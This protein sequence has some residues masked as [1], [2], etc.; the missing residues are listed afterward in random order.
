MSLDATRIQMDASVSNTCIGCAR[1]QSD[2]TRIR[3]ESR[4][5]SYARSSTAVTGCARIQ[6]DATRIGENE[7]SRFLLTAV[8][9]GCVRI[10]MDAARIRICRSQ[11]I[12]RDSLVVF[13]IS[14][15]I[16]TF[17]PIQFCLVQMQ[18][19]TFSTTFGECSK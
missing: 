3:E 9:L 2:A 6:L 1:I 13:C 7:R 15:L 19:F 11:N 5:F 4:L 10:H 12:K 17:R 18:N 16:S 8:I 14:P